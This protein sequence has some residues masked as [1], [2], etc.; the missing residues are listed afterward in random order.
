[1]TVVSPWAMFV[2]FWIPGQARNDIGRVL[3]CCWLVCCWWVENGTARAARCFA[4]YDGQVLLVVL[5]VFGWCRC[6]TL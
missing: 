5:V 1:M 4:L 3:E 2:L 6:F